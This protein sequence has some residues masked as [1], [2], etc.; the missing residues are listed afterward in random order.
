[1]TPDAGLSVNTFVTRFIFLITVA[2]LTACGK[3]DIPVR[4]EKSVETAVAPVVEKEWYPTPAHAPGQQ[5]SFSSPLNQQTAQM[6]SQPANQAYAQPP[7]VIVFQGMEYVP[8]QSQQP[9]SYQQSVPGSTQPWPRPQQPYHVPE[10]QYVQR[11]WGNA[12]SAEDQGRSNFSQQSWPAGN[13]YAPAQMPAAGGTPD[14]KSEQYWTVP[15]ANYY[16]NVW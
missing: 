12:N 13:Y 6:Q 7:P 2:L 10:S 3:S 14:N 15:P 9:W 4:K 1:M 11:P 8:A 16:G 5:G